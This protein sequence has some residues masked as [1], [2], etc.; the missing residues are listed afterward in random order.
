MSI[1]PPGKFI[2]HNTSKHENI[3][4]EV[5]QEKNQTSDRGHRQSVPWTVGLG[6]SPRRHS[7]Q[8]SDT[9]LAYSESLSVVCR[10]GDLPSALTI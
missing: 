9:I 1:E 5:A 2:K 8:S 3:V 6:C 7:K 10:L 4:G